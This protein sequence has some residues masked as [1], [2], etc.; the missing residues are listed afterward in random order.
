[1]EVRKG[2]LG[3]GSFWDGGCGF[4]FL[5]LLLIWNKSMILDVQLG[6]ALTVYHIF[7]PYI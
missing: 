2:V 1:V 3:D 6:L 4:F 5:R 7:I